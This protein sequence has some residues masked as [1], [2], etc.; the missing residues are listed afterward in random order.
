MISPVTIRGLLHPLRLTT[1]DSLLNLWT[2]EDDVLIGVDLQYTALFQ[3][4]C[5]DIF[6]MSG[7]GKDQHAA[8][9]GRMLDAL[10]EGAAAQLLVRVRYDDGSV[11]SSL[12]PAKAPDD[13]VLA[14][15]RVK[16]EEM[17]F[18]KK[19]RRVE[20]FLALTTLS[21][22]DVA[23]AFRGGLFNR[24][25]PDYVATLK[26]E[27]I[28]RCEDIG[29]AATRAASTLKEDGI[30]ARR[31]MKHEIE[32]YL[33][34]RLN[35]AKARR[36]PPPSVA[37]E[38]T[39]RSQIALSACEDSFSEVVIDD[40]YMRALN[41]KSRPETVSTYAITGLF[42]SIP[43]EFD[44]AVTL[45]AINQAKAEFAVKNGKSLAEFAFLASARQDIAAKRAHIES[46][47]F[48]EHVKA[49]H[50]KYFS[51][52]FHVVLRSQDR[53]RL[54][55][56]AYTALDA[57]RRVDQAIAIID[58]S[59]HVQLFLA[60]LPGHGHLNL[61][62]Y[63]TNTSAA[64]RFMTLSSAWGGSRKTTP[65]L[66]TQADDLRLFPI[67]LFDPSMEAKHGL[68]LGTS[69]SG[70]SFWVNSCLMGFYATSDINHVII[71]DNGGS[72]RRLC[73]A[74]GGSYLEPTIDGKYSFNPF[75]PPAVVRDAMSGDPK[76][77]NAFLQF[78]TA[79]L[80]LMLRKESLSNSEQ[81]LIQKCVLA[82][83]ERCG[84]RTPILSDLQQTFAEFNGSLADKTICTTFHDEM[85]I[86]TEGAAAP[87]FNR[88]SNIDVA[89]RFMVFDLHE[90]T[91]DLQPIVLTILRS[92]V[93]P[94]IENKMINKM[95]VLDEVWKLL[96]DQVAGAFI[97]ECYRCGRRYALSTWVITQTPVEL[98]QS[99][100]AASI[101]GN[102]P[103]K[104]ILQIKDGIDLL[105]RLEFSTEE[106]AAISRLGEVPD[107]TQY[108][109]VF[110][111][112]GRGQSRVIRSMVSPYEYWLYT[113]DKDDVRKESA[114]KAVHPDWTLAQIADE[115]SKGV[116]K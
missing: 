82:T 102:A 105:P 33:Y 63:M 65:H 22:S 49:H 100:L 112:M 95:L 2:I 47:E 28:S 92:V 46:T 98:L 17:L 96:N 108:R 37:P 104:M 68:V 78:F 53:G 11:V 34:E 6:F 52:T 25:L 62:S 88:P 71:V 69:G 72:Y 97:N 89:A 101:A 27:H 61:R 5:P 14:A 85:R 4:A 106:I 51:M 113:T 66:V 19:F 58:D 1:I 45:T 29:I 70:K 35:P 7:Q 41:L 94:K 18:Q 114:L 21:K 43:G 75:V 13:H 23:K 8:T 55:E 74:V 16:R 110:F 39:L 9:I 56:S 109:K 116:T 15:L 10:P 60:S 54:K 24:S 67:D 57:F 77:K 81:F 12:R 99:P 36:V 103:L 38:R 20:H 42:E 107:K 111:Q 31:L 59:N 91:P 73:E 84:E 86:W 115:L 40:Y 50:E 93:H 76:E 44:A 87:L 79:L 90:L 80:Q 26:K 3:L 83:Y 32:A 64:A 48:Q 30:I